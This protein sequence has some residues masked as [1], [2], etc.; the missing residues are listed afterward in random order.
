MPFSLRSAKI[1]RAVR[2]NV[3]KTHVGAS[4]A[5]RGLA[6]LT[7]LLFSVLALTPLGAATPPGR[8]GRIAFMRHDPAGHWQVWV[9]DSHLNAQRKL[10]STPSNSGWP[11]WSP[12]GSTLA[13][14]SD[15]ADPDP[16]D[17]VVINGVFTMRADGSGVTKVTGSTGSSGDAAWSPD[18]SLIA[19]GSDRG[20]Y[21]SQQ[22]IYVMGADGGNVRRVTTVP[23][24]AASD[25]SP[26]FSPDGMRLA[27]TRFRG[28]D[29]TETAALYS[30]WIDGT[31]LRRLT[32]FAIHADNSDWS[33]DGR[34]LTFD[35]Y[36]NPD[37]Y[38]DI[39]VVGADG[40]GLRN[41]TRNAVGHA[42]SADP[43]WSPDGRTILFLDNRIVGGKPR[44]GLA[45]MRPDGLV[46]RFVSPRN[47]ENHQPDW[48]TIRR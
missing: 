28:K 32:S 5:R 26:R 11:A 29:R 27:F 34:R 48:E 1:A 15:R 46:R 37:A 30:V 47:V 4:A 16:N 40:R 9:A 2:L 23:A 14:D 45:T 21:P 44:T 8:N 38:G 35:A 6:C 36:P 39:Y 17:S 25:L 7:V 3:S 13:F 22:G 10:T 31:H 33:P 18:G 24:N 42:G 19:F 41:L 12:D 43:V 20:D